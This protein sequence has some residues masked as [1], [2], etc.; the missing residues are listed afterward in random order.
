MFELNS[1]FSRGI[2]TKCIKHIDSLK[3]NE[4]MTLSPLEEQLT[5]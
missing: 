2:K 5:L 3:A 4:E 1:L